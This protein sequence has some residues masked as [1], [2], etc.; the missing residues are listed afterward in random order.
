[1][2]LFGAGLRTCRCSSRRRAGGPRRADRPSGARSWRVGGPCG[3]ARRC[4]PPTRRVTEARSSRSMPG[5]SPA[6][7]SCLRRSRRDQALPAGTPS[8]V[9][10]RRPRGSGA[11]TTTLCVLMDPGSRPRP[12]RAP[13]GCSERRPGTCG[14]RVP[15]LGCAAFTLFPQGRG[16][17]EQGRQGQVEGR[18]R[19]VRAARRQGGGQQGGSARTAPTWPRGPP[20]PGRPLHDGLHHRQH[21]PRGPRPGPRPGRLPRRNSPRRA[22]AHPPPRRLRPLRRRPRTP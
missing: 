9:T 16:V 6:R 19:A 4:R 10:A 22:P 21:R 5:G 3:R 20:G 13:G 11:W 7:R 15:G 8:T 18:V 14:G 17:R 1:M 2:P 12:G